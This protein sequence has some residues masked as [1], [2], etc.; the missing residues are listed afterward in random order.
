[1]TLG[2]TAVAAGVVDV[3]FLTAVIARQQVPAEGFSPAVHQ[4]V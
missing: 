1:M 4:I 3:V 2:A